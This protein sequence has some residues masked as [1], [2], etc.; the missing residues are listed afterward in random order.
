MAVER[1]K[2]R[3]KERAKGNRK[4][5]ISPKLSVLTSRRNGTMEDAKVPNARI[6]M[7]CAKPRRSTMH[8]TNL[9]KRK[10]LAPVHLVLASRLAIP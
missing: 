6:N 3:E 4:D 1:V 9:G 8:S 7:K 10:A 5:Q 2:E